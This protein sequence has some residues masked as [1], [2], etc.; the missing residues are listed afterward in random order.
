M[1]YRF[2]IPF[3]LICFLL[4]TTVF[5]RLPVFGVT[6]DLVLAFLLILPL[7]YEGNQALVFALVFGLLRDVCF[8][9]ATGPTALIYFVLAGLVSL[10]RGRFYAEKFYTI[11]L[12]ILPG[13]ALFHVLYWAYM[14]M[15]GRPYAFLAMAERLP[16]LLL[17]E[18]VWGTLLF[19]LIGRNPARFSRDRDLFGKAG[20]RV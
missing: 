15:L 14:R 3:L 7:Y 9:A 11:P 8:G 20:V 12:V 4:Q 19:L 6:P 16:G 10:L 18:L 13:T 1:K 5:G 17:L 2:L